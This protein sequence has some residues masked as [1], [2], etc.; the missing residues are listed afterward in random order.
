MPLQVQFF[1]SVN[2]FEDMGRMEMLCFLPLPAA[3]NTYKNISNGIA[4]AH[5]C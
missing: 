2:G 3:E 1:H 5:A 4:G